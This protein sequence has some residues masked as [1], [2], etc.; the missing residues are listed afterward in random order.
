M[1][2]SIIPAPF[3]IPTIRAPFDKVLLRT[4]GNRSVVMIA[5][6][7]FSTEPDCKFFTAFGATSSANSF[8]G[9]LHPITPVLDGKTTD[10]DSNPSSFATDAQTSS[11]SASPS[12]PPQT[13][14][15]LLLMT[16]VWSGPPPS[17]RFRPTLTGAPGNLF[18]VKHAAQ[19]SVGPSVKW[20]TVAR[21]FKYPRPGASC[22]MNVPSAVPVANPLGNAL[23]VS[24]YARYSSDVPKS[25][26]TVGVSAAILRDDVV[27]VAGDVDVGLETDE[28]ANVG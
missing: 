19:L 15:T 21:I 20:M 27:F 6:A 7:A 23:T 24:R 1:L 16:R 5:F 18:D 12:P 17:K 13:L 3:A 8:A 4:L 11:A 26:R 22:E 28:K 10:G 25:G 9:S 2:G 14:D